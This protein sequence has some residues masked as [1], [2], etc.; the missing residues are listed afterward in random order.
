MLIH[1]FITVPFISENMS[2]SVF[3]GVKLLRISDNFILKYHE[4]IRKVRMYCAGEGEMIDG[5]AYHGTTVLDPQM[6][7]NLKYELLPFFEKS[8]EC[9][10]LISILTEAIEQNMYEMVSGG[11]GFDSA[12]FTFF[13][14]SGVVV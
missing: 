13:V 7:A 1:E 2:F 5:L 4:P 11:R 10:M 3:N 9:R 14:C 12:I 6:A 8:E